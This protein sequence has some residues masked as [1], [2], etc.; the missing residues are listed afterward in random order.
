MN[1]QE[2][3]LELL[4]MCAAVIVLSLLGI[5]AGVSRGLFGS[6]DGLLMLV[7]CVMM[8]LIFALLLF[9]LAKERGWLGKHRQE[10]GPEASSAKGK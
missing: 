1:G 2:K 4:A 6:L 9:A 3:P 8:A 7:V 5:A 10:K